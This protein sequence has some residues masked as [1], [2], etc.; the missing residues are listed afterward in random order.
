MSHAG[1]HLCR[2]EVPTRRLEEPERFGVLERRRVRHVD[3]NL[4]TFQC[5]GQPL[6][7]DGVDARGG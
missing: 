2:Q 1:G 7:S 3:D 5:L 4:D 6:P